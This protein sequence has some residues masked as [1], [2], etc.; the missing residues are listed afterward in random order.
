MPKSEV[1]LC[2]KNK[3]DLKNEEFVIFDIIDYIMSSRCTNQIREA[4]GGT[5]SVMYSTEFFY[6]GKIAESSI[7]FQTRPEMTDILVAD[8]WDLITDMATAGP[9]EE[10]FE[11]ARKYL[12]KRYY[13][14]KVKVK[15]NLPKRMGAYILSEKFGIDKTTDYIKTLEKLTPKDVKKLAKKLLKGDSM[16]SVYTEK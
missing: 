15:N 1:K 7:S 8:A 6:E 13:E 16:L 10:E 3:F 12:N 2:F 11:H 4:R 9:T 14:Q 5:Y